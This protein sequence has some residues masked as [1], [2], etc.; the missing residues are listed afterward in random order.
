[1]KFKFLNSLKKLTV[2][3]FSIEMLTNIGKLNI[4]ILSD[5]LVRIRFTNKKNFEKDF[6]YAVIKNDFEIN[7]CKVS[8]E[9]NKIIFTTNKLIIE[10]NKNPLRIIFK[11]L[12]ENIISEDQNNFSISTFGDEITTYKS[13]SSNE[14]FFGLGEKTGNLNKKGSSFKMWNTDF[15]AY[16]TKK[17]PL[18]SSIPFFIGIKNYKAYGY[19]LDN[20]SETFFDMSAS[21]ERYYSFGVKDGEL[22]Y[23]FFYGENIKTVIERYTDLTGKPEIPPIWALGYQQCRWGYFPDSLVENTVKMFRD[24]KIPLDVIYLD[25]DWMDGY[26]VFKWDKNHFPN[27]KSLNKKLNDMGVK[28][29]TIID[30]AIKSDS[31]YFACNSG[32]KGNHF[33]KYFDGELYKGNVWAGESYFPDFTREKTRTWWASF[34][35]D[36][37]KDGVNGFWNDMNEPAVWG[38]TFPDITIFDYD[39]LKKSHKES[40]NVYGMQMARATY[41]GSKKYLNGFRPFILTRASYSGIQRFSALWTGDNESREDDYLQSVV[42]M[43]DLS[44][45]GISFCGADIGGFEGEPS[46]K[47][48]ERWIQL[49]A[50]YPFFRTHSVKNSKSQEPWS[51]GED[52]ENNIRET[53]KTRYKLLP[54]I[55]TAFYEAHKYGIPIIKPLFWFNQNDESCYIESNQYQFYFGNSLLVITPKIN[56]DY[57]KIYL[58]EGIWYDFNSKQIY[59]GKSEIIFENKENKLP[60]FVKGGSII[61]MRESQDYTTQNELK[62]LELH[63]YPFNNST[64]Y[65]YEDDGLTYKYQNN[66]YLLR[67]MDLIHSENILNINIQHQEGSFNTKIE[68]IKVYVYN[69]SSIKDIYV[70][71]N[72]HKFEIINNTLIF[73]LKEKSKLEIQILLSKN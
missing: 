39:G 56:Q 13:V 11:D 43:Q 47:L 32:L 62:N 68:N 55:Y 69:I 2:N 67:K 53:I 59:N 41:Q 51:F 20:T 49:G 54:Y 46:K 70:N 24:K 34:F 18:Y 60:V 23:Y 58:P 66:D 37:I 5:D 73:Q 35:K 10:V 50:F 48:F 17:D 38:Q 71:Q 31:N 6:S 21:Q 29:V 22:N 57:T 40:H 30:P 16:G 19:F 3:E 61:P 12:E 28:S 52:S 8:E 7:S 45:S 64:H 72:I 36:M 15:P 63:V 27:P 14:K 4:Y 25:I 9:K 65:F 26:R 44:L 42:M 33:I 1:L